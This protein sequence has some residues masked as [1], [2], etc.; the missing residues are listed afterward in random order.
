MGHYPDQ[1][2][3]GLR[4][5]LPKDNGVDVRPITITPILGNIMEMILDN[6]M[7]F[8]ET[9]FYTGDKYNGGFK[10]NLS[11][12]DNTWVYPK[13]IVSRQKA[14]CCLYRLQKGI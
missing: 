11:T 8:I 10:K 9:A 2:A 1:W 7:L 13:A 4:I 14:A 6:R 3:E 5:A 12:S